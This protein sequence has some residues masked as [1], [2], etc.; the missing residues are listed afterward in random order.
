MEQETTQQTTKMYVITNLTKINRKLYSILKINIGRAIPLRSLLYFFTA[1][2]LVFIVRHIPF[3]NYLV[4]WIPFT[5]AYIG[6]PIL[7]A[8]LLGGIAGEDRTPL[9]LF[10][11]FFSYYRRQQRNTN[12]FRG[13]EV[14]KPVVYQ[15]KGMPTYQVKGKSKP[16]SKE[17]KK[18]YKLKGFPTFE[19]I[20]K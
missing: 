7:T 8:Y 19:S 5:I 2:V 6:I 10:R 20:K 17:S 9:A 3:V 14:P 16:K 15:F 4:T 13:K 1:L 11:S 12:Y 18:D